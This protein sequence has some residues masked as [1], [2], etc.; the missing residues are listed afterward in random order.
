MKRR[1]L[2]PRLEAGLI[3]LLYH[4]FRLLP[5]DTASALG[6]WIGRTF[7]PRL[8]LSRRARR[9]LESA[10]PDM[11]APER[12]QVI[13]QMWDNLGRTAGEFPHIDEFGFGPG[14]RVEVDGHDQLTRMRDDG[15]PGLLF[16]GHLANWELL[17]PTGFHYGLRVHL[18]YRAPNNP[19]LAWVYRRGRRNK[20]VNLIPKGATG[21]RTAL[22][23]LSKGEHLGM[24]VDQK[25]NDGIAVP[26]FGRDAMTAPALAA[27]ALKYQCPVLPASIVRLDGARFRV[28]IHPPVRVENTGN[29]QRELHVFMTMV[30]EMLEGWI[31][32]NPGQ[33]LWLH[34]R[35]PEI[36]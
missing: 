23:M 29:R 33:W 31:R 22:E 26:F 14:E 35:W 20:G 24:L 36:G 4:F 18:I 32:R 12:D 28:T 19:R 17:G 21:A 1:E 30:N 2:P 8:T 27:F 5:L 6:G 34:R 11:T 15:L 10:L 7:G 3:W 9:N 16:S 25:M 13:R